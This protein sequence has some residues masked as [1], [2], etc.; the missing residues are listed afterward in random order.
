MSGVLGVILAGGQARRMGGGDKCLLELG[1]Q[2]LL[3]RAVERLRG[4]VADMVLNANG[5]AERFD[6]ADLR[7]VADSFPGFAGPLAGVLAGME[8]AADLGYDR[9]VTVAADTPFFPT[10]LVLALRTAVVSDTGS[11]MALAAT[12]DPDGTL[13]LHP[14]FGLWQVAHADALRRAL[15]GG[16]RK[17]LDFTDPLD[18]AV[19]VFATIP[20]DPFF[21]INRPEDLE[22]AQQLLSA[23]AR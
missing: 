14:T 21:N 4:Q 19:T 23:G 9:I 13:R 15:K 11:D 12:E 8:T 5:P 10:D 16:V 2:T 1:G 17:V 7:V 18:A 6:D 22:R 20:V 3:A